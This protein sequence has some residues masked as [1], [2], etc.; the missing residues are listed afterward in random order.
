MSGRRHIVFVG[1]G[2]DRLVPRDIQ[3]GVRAGGMTRVVAGLKEG[4]KVVSSGTFLVAAESRLRSAERYWG[5]A[6]D[7]P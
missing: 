4:D 7:T 5:A 6:H 3:V 2:E 1:G